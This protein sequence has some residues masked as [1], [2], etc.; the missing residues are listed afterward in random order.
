MEPAIA[1]ILTVADRVAALDG[2]VSTVPAP[3]PVVL[4]VL[5]LGC[6]WVLLWQGRARVLG[7]APACLALAIWTQVERPLLLVSADG[8][9]V[10]LMTDAGRSLSKPR[11]Q[12]FAASSWLENDGDAADQAEAYDRAGFEGKTGALD[13]TL[14]SLPAHHIWGRGAVDRASATCVAGHVVIA[15]A[16]LGGRGA[17]LMIDRA[18]LAETG[19]VAVFAGADGLR[20]EPTRTGNRP[21]SG[22]AR[23]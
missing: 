1:W 6:L 2:A 16:D 19:P 17:C 10:G 15:A 4:P 22:G 8:G 5:A 14:A 9:L 11:G 12:G 13:F 21:W 7:V 3:Q 20:L 18:K 23:Q